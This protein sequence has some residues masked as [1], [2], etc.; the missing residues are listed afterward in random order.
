MNWISPQA[1]YRLGVLGINARNRDF[2]ARYNPRRAFPLVDDKLKTKRILEAEGLATPALLHVVRHQFEVRGIESRLAAQSGF[3][4]KPA[5]GSG[6]KGI[7]VIER[8]EGDQFVKA[9][10]VRVGIE[11]LQRHVS[12]ALAGLYSLGGQPDAVII[13]EL[14]EFDPAFTGLSHE[15]V[16][17]IR[18]V[19]FQGYPVMAM[20]RLA[21]HASDGKANLHQGAVGVGLD[22]ATGAAIRAVQY[23]R[24]IREHPDTGQ[25]LDRIQIP[26][27][28]SMLLLAARC[29]EPTGLGYLGADLV[30]DRSKGAQLLELNARPGLAIQVASGR[31]LRPRLRAIESRVADRR[32][33][34]P[35]ARVA[36][37]V[38]AF[39]V[40]T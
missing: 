27:W 7:L 36:H 31:G 33:E 10:G 29:Y 19:V 40:E 25:V 26:D 12:N 1:L 6:G 30:L 9:S 14:I 21:T 22:L 18:I 39:A 32:R 35:E 24:P 16:P 34:L 23:A 28:H 37:V 5:K 4:I 20:L 17:D 8:R 38:E 3:C 13:E 11:Q 2:V 15:G